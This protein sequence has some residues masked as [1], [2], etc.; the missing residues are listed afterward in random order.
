MYACMV[1]ALFQKT[2]YKIGNESNCKPSHLRSAFEELFICMFI[3]VCLFIHI[4]I[5]VMPAHYPSINTRGA[6]RHYIFVHDALVEC[7]I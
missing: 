5:C 3:C 6:C 2:I 4:Y 1:S 7:P